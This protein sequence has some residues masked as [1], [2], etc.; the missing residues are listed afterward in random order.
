MNSNDCDN[1]F[2]PLGAP[3]QILI[4]PDSFY[5]NGGPFY[6]TPTPTTT[7]ANS[8]KRS[9]NGGGKEEKANK[10]PK[11]GAKKNQKKGNQSDKGCDV[12]ITPQVGAGAVPS[13]LNDF[14]NLT[15]S[16]LKYEMLRQQF[17]SLRHDFMHLKY[18]YEVEIAKGKKKKKVNVAIDAPKDIPEDNNGYEYVPTPKKQSKKRAATATSTSPQKKKK[19]E[20]V[21]DGET[22]QWV[23]D[24]FENN[25]GQLTGSSSSSSSSS[26]SP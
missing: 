25:D 2:S 11:K 16:C 19:I 6:S 14:V 8:K 12:E 5:E 23:D 15:G 7:P 17:A 1:G 26:S 9:A 21:D 13:T 22:R 3:G 20:S 4:A 18:R 10:T 24:S